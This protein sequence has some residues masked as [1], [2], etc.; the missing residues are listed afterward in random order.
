[1]NCEKEKTCQKELYTQR[2]NNTNDYLIVVVLYILLV[3]ILSA[4]LFR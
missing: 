4:C 2:C 3:I 1:M